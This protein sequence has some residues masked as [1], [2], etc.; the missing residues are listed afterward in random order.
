MTYLFAG[1]ED[2]DF[3]LQP[4]PAS[5]IPVGSSDSSW[6]VDTVTGHYRSAY[7]RCALSMGG[8]NANAVLTEIRSPQFAPQ[9]SLWLS[10]RVYLSNGLSGGGFVYPVRFYD[11]NGVLRLRIRTTAP[12]ST[13]IVEKIDAAFAATQLGGSSSSGFTLTP[14]APEKLDVFVN[15]AVAGGIQVYLGGNLIFSFSGD[16]TTNSVTTLGAIGLSAVAAP[17]GGGGATCWSEVVVSTTDTRQIV[18]LV[19]QSPIIAGSAQDWTSVSPIS[20]VG[21]TGGA[22]SGNFNIGANTVNFTKLTLPIG[23][24]IAS[25]S[26]KLNANLTGTLQMAVY[27]DS[28]G[29]PAGAL[30]ASTNTLTNPTAAVLTLT[31]SSTVKVSPYQVVWIAVLG[32]ATMALA[33]NDTQPLNAGAQVAGSS[34]PS[35]G[36]A[37]LLSGNNWV[38]ATISTIAI[39]AYITNDINADNIATTDKHESYQVSTALPAGSYSIDAV[40]VSCRAAA[41]TTGATSIDP[42]VRISGTGYFSTRLTL[43]TTFGPLQG[44]FATNP[45]TTAPWVAGDLPI[46]STAYNIGFHVP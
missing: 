5:T 26:C 44:V 10:A 18:G 7:A 14:A 35:N 13:F 16:V 11:T 9:G 36:P 21:N 37:S 2:F 12:G 45:A 28:G 15:Y 24:T 42:S 27:A 39:G 40:I 31:P 30:L 38:Q 3:Y 20:T 1:G 17:G 8:N 41:G 22:N 29:T 25:L 6:K 19:T 32:S 46:G 33:L 43:P 4:S 34:F 23:G